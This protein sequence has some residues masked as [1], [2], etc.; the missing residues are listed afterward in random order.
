MSIAEHFQGL[1]WTEATVKVDVEFRGPPRRTETMTWPRHLGVSADGKTA[2]ELIGGEDNIRSIGLLG[3][4]S[5]KDKAATQR[6]GAYAAICLAIVAPQWKGRNDWMAAQMKR[7]R[8]TRSAHIIQNG[9]R[10]LLT[11]DPRTSLF[12]FKA[13][14]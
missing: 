7:L 3:E 5:A 9:W 11:F 4:M 10:I 8:V 6:N 2:L 12:N 1:T 13:S 14:R